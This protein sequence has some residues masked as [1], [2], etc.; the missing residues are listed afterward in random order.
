M[1]KENILQ[2]F[3]E[4]K[5]QYLYNGHQKYQSDIRKTPSGSILDTGWP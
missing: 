3:T 5:A 4:R 2:R 1:K